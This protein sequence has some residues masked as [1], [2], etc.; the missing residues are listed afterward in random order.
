M[1]T[2]MMRMLM[3][4]K[5]ME[6]MGLEKNYRKLYM[7]QFY[8]LIFVVAIFIIFVLISVSGMFED[9]TPVHIKIVIII[10]GNYPIVL[11]YVN[12]VSFLHWV[13]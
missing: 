13:R 2:A 6:Q 10:A 5:T 12:D 3:C 7:N 9:N 8:V 1:N 11:L 4:D